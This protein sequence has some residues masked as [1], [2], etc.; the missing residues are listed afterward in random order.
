MSI[1]RWPTFLL[2]QN[3]SVLLL[4]TKPRSSR[5]H[6]HSMLSMMGDSK[7]R[8]RQRKHF[9][10]DPGRMTFTNIPPE[11]YTIDVLHLILRVAPPLFRQTIQANVNTATMQRLR[12]GS[13]TSANWSSAIRSPY[14]QTQASRSSACPQS[15][16]QEMSAG[17]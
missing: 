13:T 8:T 3:M 6:Q 5:G 11:D 10:G 4:I 12:S 2:M 14:R 9:G 17:R 1:S 7:R 16:G 15:R